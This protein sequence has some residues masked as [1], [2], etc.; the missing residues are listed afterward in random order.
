MGFGEYRPLVPNDTPEG[1]QKNRRVEITLT[2]SA[3]N[4]KLTP[5]KASEDKLK[6]KQKLPVYKPTAP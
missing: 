6:D 4:Q 2:T 5:E 3:F 1:R